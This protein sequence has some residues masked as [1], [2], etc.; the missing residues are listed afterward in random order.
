M[1]RVWQYS[2]FRQGV[3]SWNSPGEVA[4]VHFRSKQLKTICVER[5]CS[6]GRCSTTIPEGANVEKQASKRTCVYVLVLVL[7]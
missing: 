3:G 2:L 4:D 7:H 1:C 5:S 6:E